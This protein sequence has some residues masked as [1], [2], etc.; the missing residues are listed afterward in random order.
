MAGDDRR[1]VD[2]VDI[3]L[4]QRI[5]TRDHTAVAELYDR[6]SRLLFSL[7]TRIVHDRAEA[8]EV[9][10]EVFLTVWTKAH[11]YD[12][13]LGSPMGWLV[14]LA[15][16]RAIDRFRTLGARARAVEA[17]DEPQPGDNPEA[18][19]VRNQERSRVRQALGTLPAEQRQLIEQAYFRGLTHS[20][21]AE[22]FGLPLGTVKTRVRSGLQTLRAQLGVA[23][24]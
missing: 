7:I 5:S 23:T 6:H 17:M 4:L 12:S 15:R 2:A 21:L 19:T 14:R 10:Q 16:N 8:E 24:V 9:L 20:E 18:T 13:R 3:A 1:E 11:T 22:A